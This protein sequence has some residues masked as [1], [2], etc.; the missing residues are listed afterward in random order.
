[1]SIR[2]VRGRVRITV[3][4]VNRPLAAIGSGKDVAIPVARGRVASKCKVSGIIC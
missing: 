2:T 1:M 3:G 4:R